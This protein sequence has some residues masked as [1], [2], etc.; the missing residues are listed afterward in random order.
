MFYAN[1]KLLT[2]NLI[3]QN[4]KYDWRQLTQ[5]VNL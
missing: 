2:N 3:I 5:S 4:V 1:H